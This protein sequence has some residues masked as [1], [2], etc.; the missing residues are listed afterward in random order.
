MIGIQLLEAPTDRRG[1]PRALR[2][3][4]DHLPPGTVIKRQLLVANKTAK[5][6]RV[7]LYPAAATIEEERFVFGAARTPN[8]LTSWISL[9]RE[10]LE[11][12]PGG[13]ARFR[14]T[15]TV[16]PQASAGERYAV[17]WA[18]VSSAPDP[19]ANVNKIHRVGVRTYLS[20]GPGGEPPSS[21]TIGELSPARDT[22]GVPSV[23]IAVRNTGERALDLTGSVSL[24]DGPA[25]L[26]AG[27]FDVVDGTTITPGES[28]TVL[29]QLPRELPNGPWQ[30]DVALASGQVKESAT[31]RITFPDPGRVGEPGSPLSRLGPLWALVAGSLVVGLVVLTGLLLLIRRSRR[32]TAV[33][34]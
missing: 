34:G 13:K 1:D 30:I 16:P 25:D 29:A 23:R 15:I 9:D 26:R 20:V 24:S 22:L 19:T 11:L 28:G 21:F 8:E 31:A 7:D 4:V 27:P 2:Y 33:S 5:T 3:I 18:S 10:T 17:I 6:Q 32:R 14:A 12:E